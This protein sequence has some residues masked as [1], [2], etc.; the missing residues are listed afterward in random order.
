M[1]RPYLGVG[2]MAT[3][4]LLLT[5]GR[6]HAQVPLD[7]VAGPAF[8]S[9][10]TDEFDTSSRTGFFAGIGTM[11]QVSERFA[12]RPYVSY[13][14]KGAHF[15]SDDG[16]DIYSYIEIPVFLSTGFPLSETV[17][18]GISLG[19]QLAFNI[20]CNE[21]VPGEPD[22]DCKDYEDYGGST[23]FGVVGSVGLQFPVGSSSLGVGAG[24]DLGL[25]DVF[26]DIQGGYK[27]RALFIFV[28]YGMSLGS[29]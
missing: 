21:T 6:V 27:N 9:V 4:G 17:N 3:L 20:K 29:M 22:Y 11:F 12:I 26:K 5:T 13:V 24:F 8:T 16:E 28:G 25:K 1:R 2:L 7:I 18:L 15:A 10:S 19:P 23:E 14:Q